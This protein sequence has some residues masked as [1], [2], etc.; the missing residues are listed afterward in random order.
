MGGEQNTN[1]I[2]DYGNR[3]ERRPPHGQDIAD[4]WTMVNDERPAAGRA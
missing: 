3:P 1:V 2:R 4:P